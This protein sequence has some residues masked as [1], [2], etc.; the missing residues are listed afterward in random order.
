MRASERG[1][2][3]THKQTFIPYI[4]VYYTRIGI[5]RE[6]RTYNSERE[7]KRGRENR[8]SG[9]MNT[10]VVLLPVDGRGRGDAAA[11]GS[12]RGER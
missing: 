2:V 5:E 12:S 9:D 4:Y 1:R 3:N 11:D 7:R 10:V 8:S 6:G